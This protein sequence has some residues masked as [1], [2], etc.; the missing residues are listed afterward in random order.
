ME[1]RELFRN[2]RFVA[3]WIGVWAGMLLAVEN[4]ATKISLLMQLGQ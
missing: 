2:P 1:A 3:L 4:I